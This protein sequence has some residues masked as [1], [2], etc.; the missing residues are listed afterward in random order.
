MLPK[1][2]GLKVP[3]LRSH[4]D[5]AWNL[6]IEVRRAAGD[7][8]CVSFS[9]EGYFIGYECSIEY[10]YFYGYSMK[11]IPCNYK[12]LLER[13]L[14]KLR[15]VIILLIYSS[16]LLWLFLPSIPVMTKLAYTRRG[17]KKRG[18]KSEWLFLYIFSSLSFVKHVS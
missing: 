5:C 10:E 11:V 6:L 9:S 15:M 7:L 1:S 12:H 3:L 4:K 17:T 18:F 8:S 14:K 16:S 13:N 2:L